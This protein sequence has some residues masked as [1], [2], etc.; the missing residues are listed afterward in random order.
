MKKAQEKQKKAEV[1]ARK[2]A[3]GAARL[4]AMTPDE[5]AAHTAA[6]RAHLEER[7]L[8][9]QQKHARLKQARSGPSSP[10]SPSLASRCCMCSNT[11]FA[12]RMLLI[13]T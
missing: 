3:E 9:E 11:I 12:Q 7:R 1:Q 8:A 13:Q 5:L 10:C 4:A 2:K 6:R